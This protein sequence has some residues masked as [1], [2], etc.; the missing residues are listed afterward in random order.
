MQRPPRLLKI[1][2]KAICILLDVEPQNKVTKEGKNKLS[3]WRASIS[4]LVLADPNF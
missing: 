2:M 1:V 3:Y 4:P